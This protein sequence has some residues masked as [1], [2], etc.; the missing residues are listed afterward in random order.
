MSRQVNQRKLGDICLLFDLFFVF[1]CEL[2]LVI[3]ELINVS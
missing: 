1:F 3:A 2:G